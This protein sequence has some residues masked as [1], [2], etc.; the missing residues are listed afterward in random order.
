MTNDLNY[1]INKN[2]EREYYITG[3]K[4]RNAKHLQDQIEGA[5]LALKGTKLTKK[6]L[7]KQLDISVST[8]KKYEKNPDLKEVVLS[9]NE[10]IAKRKGDAKKAKQITKTFEKALKEEVKT[11][12]VVK[13]VIINNPNETTSDLKN[14]IVYL[15]FKKIEE[16]LRNGDYDDQQLLKIF[17]EAVKMSGFTKPDVEITNTL[18]SQKVFVTKE[19]IE[20]TNQIIDEVL[21]EQ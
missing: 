1:F 5:L 13:R 3:C 7:C 9:A 2:G 14:N 19:D 4:F 8:W 6:S 11:K 10:L 16:K 18:A 15:S 17:M 20:K 12:T 21:N